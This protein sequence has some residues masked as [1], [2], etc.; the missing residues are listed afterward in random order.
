M[1]PED[2]PDP[3]IEQAQH[4]NLMPIP[5]MGLVSQPSLEV[6]NSVGLAYGQRHITVLR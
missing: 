6:T 5:V 4:R 2:A 3:R 1:L